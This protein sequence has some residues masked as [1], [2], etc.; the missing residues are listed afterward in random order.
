MPT[1]VPDFTACTYPPY[2]H[3]YPV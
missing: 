1:K 3:I 2:K